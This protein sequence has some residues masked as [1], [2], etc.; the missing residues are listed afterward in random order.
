VTLARRDCIPTRRMGTR[1]NSKRCMTYHL[2]TLQIATFMHPTLAT[3]TTLPKKLYFISTSSAKITGFSL[4]IRLIEAETGGDAGAAQPLVVSK[5]HVD[6]HSLKFVESN[7]VG[8]VEPV[9]FTA[10][11]VAG[12][13][14][15]VL[16]M[17]QYVPLA[18]KVDAVFD[19]KDD[20]RV[21]ISVGV[22]IGADN[23]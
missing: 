17:C 5:F 10:Q 21:E 6:W 9:N 11:M 8:L 22:V 3:C 7:V 16:K 2:Y 4:L 15:V 13:V 1:K 23:G 12:V 18:H 14:D 19:T 20:R